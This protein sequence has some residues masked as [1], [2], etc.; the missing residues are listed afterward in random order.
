MHVLL[1]FVALGIFLGLFDQSWHRR[2][3]F[4]P[5]APCPTEDTIQI[6]PIINSYRMDHP[7]TGHQAERVVTT[8]HPHLTRQLPDSVHL[9]VYHPKG[10]SKYHKWGNKS[11]E[12]SKRPL[13]PCAS[14]H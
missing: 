14:T 10:R 2:P 5:P 4:L 8:P 13:T 6:F 3:S 7:H 1:Q 11:P 9:A 12:P